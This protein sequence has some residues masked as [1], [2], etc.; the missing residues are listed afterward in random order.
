MFTIANTISVG[1]YT[2]GFSS[3]FLDLLTVMMMM[4]IFMMIYDDFYD[5]L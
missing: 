5:D 3:S 2:V 1:T 4:M